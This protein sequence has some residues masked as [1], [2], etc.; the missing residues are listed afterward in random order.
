MKISKI[1]ALICIF[2]FSLGLLNGVSAKEERAVV[3]QALNVMA[4]DSNVAVSCT[5]ERRISFVA[6]DFERALNLSG[7]EYITVTRLPEKTDGTL[8]LG[9]SEINEGQSVSRANI[10]Y[11]TFDFLDEETNKSSFTFTTNHSAH[12]IECKLYALKYANSA[13]T[14][15]IGGATQASTYKNVS[16][17]GK[18][19]AY[20]QEGDAVFFEIVKQ[21]ENGLLTVK[22][23]G[24]YIYSPTSGYVGEDSFKYVALDEYGN[25]STPR[26]I[27]LTVELQRSSLVFAD[28]A[29]GEYQVAAINLAEK[30]VVSVGEVDGEF[31]FYPSYGLGRLEYLV[32]A[33]KTLGIEVESSAEKTVFRDDADI[34]D[35]LKGY[36]NTALK[37]GFVSGRIDENGNPVFSPNEKITRAE[38]AVMLNN[39]CELEVPVSKPLF[40]DRNSVPAW[41]ESA[42]YCLAANGIMP[43]SNGCVAASEILNRGEGVYML[44]NLASLTKKK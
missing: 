30:G 26:E 39:M 14:T 10:A 12:E 21:P 35:N 28:I 44:Y 11:M 16:L 40:T 37:L 33:M 13:P 27:E 15:D 2:S 23:S 34:P 17:Y 20:D 24:E 25:Y 9:G 42:V 8:Y 22:K 4:K 38:A 32:M 18:L 43:Y 3:S 19:N 41:A 1:F 6:E 5:A 29:S 36:V 31:Y 7:V